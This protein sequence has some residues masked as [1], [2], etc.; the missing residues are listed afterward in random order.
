[1]KW[2]LDKS[3]GI[4]AQLCAQIC[5]RIAAGILKPGDKLLSVRELAVEAGVNPNTVQHAFTQLEQQGVLY[6]VP[7]TGW[8]VCEDTKT[9]LQVRRELVAE[10]VTAFFSDMADLGMLPG[11]I[12]EIVKEWKL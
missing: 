11:E 2:K 12:K 1:M 10:K 4:C 8:F 9:A 3:R 7:G 6:S 5:A